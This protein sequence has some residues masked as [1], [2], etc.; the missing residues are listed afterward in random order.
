MIRPAT[1]PL[2]LLL[3]A[4]GGLPLLALSWILW[5]VWQDPGEALG[6]NWLKAAATLVFLEFGLLH[7]GAFMAAGPIVC[8]RWWQHLLWFLGFAACYAIGIVLYTHWTGND[9]VFWLVIGVLVSRILTLLIFRDKAEIIL[10][11]QRSAFGIVLL[12]L[13]A[14]VCFI[15]WPELGITEALR[16]S[17]FGKGDDML[18]AHPQ[19]T[20]VWGM[21]YFALMGLAELY[22]GWYRP[23]WT[24]EQVNDAWKALSK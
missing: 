3:A 10:M 19:R 7:S 16:Y 24:K 15:P 11:L 14:V 21:V 9:Y 22:A 5:L 20:L 1:I 17:T 12:I 13:T 6:G 4:L 23:D 18:N 2:R 8:R